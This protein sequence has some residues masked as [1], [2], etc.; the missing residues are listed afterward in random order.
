MQQHLTCGGEKVFS[1]QEMNA[2]LKVYLNVTAL[3]CN[4]IKFIKKKIIS[5]G[6]HC[7]F[8]SSSVSGVW[9]IETWI[10][11]NS[12]FV[13][14]ILA[15][16]LCKP[17]DNIYNIDFIRFKI[18]NLETGTILFEIAK[19]PH[20]GSVNRPSPALGLSCGPHEV[21]DVYPIMSTIGYSFPWHSLFSVKIRNNTHRNK[22]AAMQTASTS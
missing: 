18:R 15:G 11:L 7:S 12:G 13:P 8:F 22:I 5:S 17:E 9:A 10:K 1:Y 6:D 16:Y 2:S 3:C 14:V 4:E 21:A 20:T 19:P